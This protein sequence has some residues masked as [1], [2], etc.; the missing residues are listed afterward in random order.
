M[1]LSY[2]HRAKDTIIAMNFDN[3]GM[4]Y[5]ISTTNPNQFVVL[6][7]GGRGKYPSFG[8]NSDGIFV[9]NL[10]VNSNGK[11]LYKRPS[12]KVT[13]TTKLVKDVLDGVILPDSIEEYLNNIE[14]V[15]TPDWS[16]HNMICDSQANVWVV[17]PGRGNIY[18]SATSASYFVMSNFSIWDYINENENCGCTRYKNVSNE[19]SKFNELSIE[20]A[21]EILESAKQ[22]EGEW[23]TDLSMVYSRNMNTVYYCFNRNF[24]ERLKYTFSI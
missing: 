13:H 5:K 1:C 15:N 20:Q 3:N 6:V 18:N 24:D 22:E 4:K 7:D 17:E 9:N 23:I 10:V 21:F 11:G 12:K 8:I 19:L 2:I 14:V 16:T